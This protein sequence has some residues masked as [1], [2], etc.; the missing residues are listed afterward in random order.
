MPTVA[1]FRP[2]NKAYTGSGNWSL[3]FETPTAS[4]A[5]PTAPGRLLLLVGFW[6]K[7]DPIILPP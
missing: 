3:T 5:I 4:K 7:L 2:D 1:E 6:N